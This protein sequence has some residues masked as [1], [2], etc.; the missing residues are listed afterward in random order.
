MS[1]KRHLFPFLKHEPTPRDRYAGYHERVLATTIDVVCLYT[2]FNRAFA[3][4]R[5][6]IY[7]DVLPAV[8]SGYGENVSWAELYQLVVESGFAA[9]VGVEVAIEM[10]VLG[11]VLILSQYYLKTTPGR[12]LLGLKLVDAKTEAEPTLWQLLR[13]FLGYFVSLPPF[14]LGYIWCAWDGKRQSWHD[15]IAGTVVLDTRPPGWYWG[16]VKRLYR[17]ARGLPEKDSNA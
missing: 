15:K 6:Q 7:G 14:M 16:H 3:W 5:W 17:R 11:G 10:T 1:W 13:R 12:W 8:P 2:V 4:L 9:L